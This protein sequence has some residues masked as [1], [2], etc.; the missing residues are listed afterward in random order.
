[1]QKVYSLLSGILVAALLM[2]GAGF[3]P[4]DGDETTVEE[5]HEVLD[6]ADAEDF[7]TDRSAYDL[8]ETKSALAEKRSNKCTA[9]STLE[10]DQLQI[11]DEVDTQNT[12]ESGLGDTCECDDCCDC[13]A[14]IAGCECDCSWYVIFC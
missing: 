10:S 7:A 1:M 8:Y 5:S 12:C 4:L 6:A 3:V 14:T 9:S 2:F 11:D 13:S